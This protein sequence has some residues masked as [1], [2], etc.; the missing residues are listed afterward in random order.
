MKTKRAILVK[1]GKF[2]MQEFDISPKPDEVLV[3]IASCGLCNWELNHWVGALGPYPQSM[4]HEWAGTVVDMGKEAKGFKEGDNITMFP[5]PDPISCVLKEG[6]SEYATISASCCVKISKNLDPKY[7]FAEPLKCIVTVLRACEPNIGDNAV[8]IG[9]GPMGLWCI[10][11]LAGNS[12]NSLIAV[13]IDDTKLGLA[14]KYGATHTIN[15]KN[16]DAFE[17][18]K[19]ITQE[20][21][22]DFVIEGTGI[23]AMMN[24]G[25][26]YV[27]E[28][29]RGKLIMMSS[30][31]DVTKEFSFKM[32]MEKS[33]EIKVA[34]PLYSLSQYDDLRRAVLLINKDVFN[35]KD[36]VSHEFALE[37]IN[38]AFE[39]L[40]NKSL[41]YLKG[42]VIP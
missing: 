30:H 1:P 23:P 14:K 11:G 12:L 39:T 34:H 7:A 8:I 31:K 38:E 32:A 2:E 33:A 20:H 27:R 26:T 19:D 36:L 25:L 17:L 29:G 13:D 15:P 10:Q 4:G 21:M 37:D 3:K 24:T 28:T 42:I 40:E 16:E 22:A 35:I 9:C 6:F 5:P 41:D 18:I